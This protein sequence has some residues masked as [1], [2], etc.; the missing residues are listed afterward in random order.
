MFLL[1]FIFL[2]FVFLYVAVLKAELIT[3]VWK[4]VVNEQANCFIEIGYTSYENNAISILNE[5]VDIQIGSTKF[6]AYHPYVINVEAGRIDVVNQVYESLHH[7]PESLVAMKLETVL[8]DHLLNKPTK[9]VVF[10]QDY[11]SQ[12]IEKVICSEFIKVA[13]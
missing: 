7:N 9:L 6:K 11:K 8:I 13:D 5:R 2:S 1:R 10:E 3:G 12:L 4:G